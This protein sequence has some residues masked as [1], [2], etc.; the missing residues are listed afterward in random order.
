MY[1]A[2]EIR[3]FLLFCILLFKYYICKN[4]K[5]KNNEKNEDVFVADDFIVVIRS[6]CFASLS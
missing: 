5:E 1:L 6:V 2:R 3:S 4:I